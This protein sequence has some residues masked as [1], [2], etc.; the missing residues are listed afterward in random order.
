MKKIQ[1]N[2][3]LLAALLTGL[4]ACLKKD[5]MN[6]DPD[7]GTKNV[8]EF[9]NTGDN[10]ASAASKYPRFYA[11]LGT[12]S[13]GQV[14]AIKLNLSYSGIETASQD[15]TV[16]LALD[17]A[18]LSLYNVTDGTGYTVP[19]T[20]VYKFPSSVIIKKGTQLSQ[21]EIIVTIASDFDFNKSYAV[22]LKISSVSTGMVSNN[23][24]SAIYSF[25]GRN[26]YDGIY[27]VKGNVTHPNAAYTGPFVDDEVA[28]NTT[29]AA[30]IAMK[31]QPFFNNGTLAT[32][33]VHPVFTVNADNSVTVSGLPDGGMAPSISDPTY[34]N[35]YDPA[36]KTFFISYSYNAAVP[37]IIYDTCVYVKP[38]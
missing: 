37:R 7:S 19:P 29:G 20:S 34:K 4:S 25:G 10:L 2:I 38:R 5:A 32:F 26:K 33:D 6:I 3:L 15:I 31:A 21:V 16:N 36:T 35:R 13:T 28:F 30:T 12:V 22:P 14:S 9:A 23:F 8:V 18:A 24:G 11:D 17:T 1:I 27:L